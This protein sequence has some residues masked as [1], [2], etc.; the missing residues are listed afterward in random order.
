MKIFP[1]RSL[2]A[3]IWMIRK[4]YTH[5]NRQEKIKIVAFPRCMDLG[6]FRM[7]AHSKSFRWFSYIKNISDSHF[8]SA[9]SLPLQVF[10]SFF[11]LQHCHNLVP[12]LFSFLLDFVCLGLI[13]FYIY[14]NALR[15]MCVHID[16]VVIFCLCNVLQFGLLFVVGLFPLRCCIPL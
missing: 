16:E 6:A 15:V 4:W 13:F 8:R 3:T 14:K 11:H 2:C 5:N 9:F 7:C 10:Y 12:W 1:S